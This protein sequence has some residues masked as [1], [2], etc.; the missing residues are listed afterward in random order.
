MRQRRRVR[1]SRTSRGISRGRVAVNG[2]VDEEFV[3]E[4]AE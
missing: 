3:V 1:R 4:P 2:T